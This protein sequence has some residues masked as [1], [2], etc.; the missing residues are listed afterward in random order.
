MERKTILKIGQALSLV[1][2]A[3]FAM[4]C[5]CSTQDTLRGVDDF[6]DGYNYGKS[7]FSESND[8]DS[9]KAE[10]EIVLNENV[11]LCGEMNVEDPILENQ[12]TQEVN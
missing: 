2:F 3:G 10:S 9:D 6:V 11:K 7:I 5:G 4:A 12:N 1:T 8:D